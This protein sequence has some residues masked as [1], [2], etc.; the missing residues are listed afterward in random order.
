M[1][2]SAG[3]SATIRPGRPTDSLNC[4]SAYCKLNGL[5]LQKYFRLPSFFGLFGDCSCSARVSRS[6]RNIGPKACSARVSRPR[7]NV[8]VRRGSPDPAGTSDQRSPCSARVSRPRRNIGP[9]VSARMFGEG[10]PTPPKHRTKGLRSR[11]VNFGQRRGSVN[12]PATI[13]GHDGFAQTGI[14]AGR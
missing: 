3:F 4:L 5:R 8:H 9:K 11:L 13:A 7:R 10:L 6:R 2:V 1:R 14:G 12:S